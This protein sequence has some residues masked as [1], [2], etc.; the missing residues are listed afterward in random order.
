MSQRPA[1]AQTEGHHQSNERTES[2]PV[3]I[4][5]LSP[6]VQIPISRPADSE[7]HHVDD[8]G[9]ESRHHREAREQGH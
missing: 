9:D 4:P 2:E 8:K 6:K 7:E 3:G 5:I 1:C